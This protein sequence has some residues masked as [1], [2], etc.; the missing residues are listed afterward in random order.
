MR[1]GLAVRPVSRRS[2][3]APPS[4]RKQGSARALLA[5]ER[6]SGL[7]AEVGERTT[8]E[9]TQLEIDFASHVVSAASAT[10]A[11]SAAKASTEADLEALVV[12]G[13]RR[14]RAPDRSGGR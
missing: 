12:L 11:A 9:S 4:A 5:P 3:K 14:R 10:S 7:G 6:S 2:R 1:R 13:H 8:L